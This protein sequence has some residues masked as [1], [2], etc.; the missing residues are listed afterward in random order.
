MDFR[1]VKRSHEKFKSVRETNLG[2]RIGRVTPYQFTRLCGDGGWRIEYGVSKFL[3][4]KG[5]AWSIV[6]GKA[7]FEMLTKQ[8][9]KKP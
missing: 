4:A 2:K 8:Y 6:E 9:W 3:V 1:S 7:I 5:S